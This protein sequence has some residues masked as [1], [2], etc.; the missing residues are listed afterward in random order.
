M[1]DLHDT[2]DCPTQAM[3]SED[4]PPPKSSKPKKPPVERPY[5]ETC[6]SKFP[7]KVFE[8]L[9]K[10]FFVKILFLFQCSATIQLTAMME[11]RIKLIYLSIPMEF[12]SNTM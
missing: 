4:T 8:A 10:K 6:E 11:K 3:D 2:E 1:F 5:C 9:Q 7:K 12:Y